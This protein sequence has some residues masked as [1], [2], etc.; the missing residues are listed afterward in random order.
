MVHAL[1]HKPLPSV[2]GRKHQAPAG[3]LSSPLV[4]SA[5]SKW[6]GDCQAVPRPAGP[7]VGGPR[8]REAGPALP[9]T[10]GNFPAP[11]QGDNASARAPSRGAPPRAPP[12]GARSRPLSG[13]SVEPPPG[14]ARSTSAPAL[15]IRRPG[16]CKTPGRSPPRGQGACSLEP[17]PRTVPAPLHA[18]PGPGRR[19][20]RATPP[21]PSGRP[22]L[23]GTWRA[24][25]H[26]S[27]AGS[28]PAPRQRRRPRAPAPSAERSRLSERNAG[29]GRERRAGRGGGAGRAARA[30]RARPRRRPGERGRRARS[31]KGRAATCE[32]RGRRTR[33]PRRIPLGGGGAGFRK[34]EHFDRKPGS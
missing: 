28:A 17:A 30:H 3:N 7:G 12:P 11:R 9:G 32:G 24:A 14:P 33:A 31:R 22:P 19:R 2:P 10:A 1:N 20:P 21:N 15:A 26:Y 4:S 23:T 13:G 5:F 27:I 34:P 25:G 6:P 8:T 16:P 18:G 29:C